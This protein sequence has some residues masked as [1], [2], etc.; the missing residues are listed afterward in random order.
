MQLPRR[1]PADWAVGAASS[2][3]S[4]CKSGN[5][6]HHAQHQQNQ[7]HCQLN[8]QRSQPPQRLTLVRARAYETPRPPRQ[9]HAA[10]GMQQQARSSGYA[11]A[12]A[13]SAAGCCSTRLLLLLLLLH[14]EAAAAAAAAA[15]SHSVA[16][17]GPR[18][19]TQTARPRSR[20]AQL[21]L[22]LSEDAATAARGLLLADAA[23]A[24]CSR[25]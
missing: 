19:S 24:E 22:P 13:A 1:L 6:Q 4:S 11:A 2:R 10:A 21:P 15:R 7:Q 12:A 20:C 23:A 25:C 14:A 17:A 3:I 8:Q 18:C 5:G 16:A 9:W